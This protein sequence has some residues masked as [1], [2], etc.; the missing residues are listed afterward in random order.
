PRLYAAPGI[1]AIVRANAGAGP[2][3][4]RP[5]APGRRAR[6]ALANERRRPEGLLRPVAERWW[7]A[8]VDCPVPAASGAGCGCARP[9]RRPPCPFGGATAGGGASA[10]RGFVGW[11]PG[12]PHAGPVRG[13]EARAPLARGSSKLPTAAEPAR[14][15]AI[16][17][18][19]CGAPARP[20]R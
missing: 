4:R 2:P 11:R 16:P 12:P 9:V 19:V 18:A 15:A 5:V 13:D 10:G 20:R 6:P 14:A 3:G 1:A 7:S 8:S 17:L